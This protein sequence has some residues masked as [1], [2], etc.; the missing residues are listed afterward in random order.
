MSNIKYPQIDAQSAR[1][2]TYP[3]NYAPR[4]YQISICK[5]ALFTNTLVCLP[6]GL[7]KTLIAAVVMYNFYNWFP[8]GFSS[9]SCLAASLTMSQQEKSSFLHHPSRLYNNK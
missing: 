9:P 4:D 5:E 3:T 2:W 8:T 6:T 7:G 1:F